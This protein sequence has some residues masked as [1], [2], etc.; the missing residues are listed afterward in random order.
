MLFTFFSFIPGDLDTILTLNESPVFQSIRHL[1][2]HVRRD[3]RN[4]IMTYKIIVEEQCN[5]F[6][7][8]LF[9]GTNVNI[10]YFFHY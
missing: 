8:P 10:S 6:G 4:V 1:K 3:A 2:V 5:I 7:Q 9:H